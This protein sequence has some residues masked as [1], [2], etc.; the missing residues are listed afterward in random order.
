MNA[1]ATEKP[2]ANP[3]LVAI[4]VSVVTFM[5]V[6]DTT[7]TN[8]SLSHIAGS[9]A[10]TQEEST[11]VLTSYL[12]ANGIVLPI[13]GWLSDVMGRKRF[14]LTCIAGFTLASFAC[15]VAGSLE[16]LIAF[17]LLQGFAGGGLQPTQQ[18][19]ILD[20]FP[21]EKRGMVFGLTGVTLIAAPII[22]PTLG[23]WI[24]DNFSW[25]W[26]FFINVPVGA[27]ALLMVSRLV[28]DPPHAKATGVKSIDYIGLSLLV[29]GLGCLQ[30]VLDKGQQEDWF[31]SNFIRLFAAVSATA[32]TAAVLWLLRQKNPVVELRLL[33]DR[34]FG[35]ACALIF[36]TGFVLYGS[37]A[38]LPLLVQSQ[39]GYD[40]TLAGL[41]LSPGGVAV[42]V[43]MPLSG[44]L[45]SRVQARWLI[46]IGLSLCAT[47]MWLTM[48]VTPQTNYASFVWMRIVQVVGLP[49]LFV[50]TSTLAFFHIR[51]EQ[52]N[53]ASA[54]YA[55]SRNLGGSVGI[56]IMATYVSRHQQ[57]HQA[58]LSGHL[59]AA[60]PVYQQRL[61]ETAQ[62]IGGPGA[63]A[64]ALGHLYRELLNQAT[65]LAYHDAFMLLSL[66]MAA[67]AACTLLLPANRP[68]AAGPE[69]TAH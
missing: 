50:P 13:S 42:I 7:I 2:A 52:N 39:F 12:I 20:I 24:T 53:K 26:I 68:K 21:P 45:V 58:Y 62:G 19:I 34:A 32:L 5:E 22:G 37:S 54:L 43:L 17:R 29:L 67:G 51:K 31:D 36:F 9:M 35:M 1:A 27:V 63:T 56:A 41:V 40:A 49:F 61:R 47:G 25:R 4:V 38:L 46:G 10:A 64:S 6:L 23:G 15:G 44:R 16:M 33:K 18:A 60:D 65:I 59:G 57:I 69:T 30:V 48:Q 8:V 11:W 55:M 14:F 28:Q 3:W 66:I